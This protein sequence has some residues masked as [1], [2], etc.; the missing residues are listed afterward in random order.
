MCDMIAIIHSFQ[1][2]NF[3][4]QKNPTFIFY[5]FLYGIFQ[6]TSPHFQGGKKKKSPQKSPKLS[7]LHKESGSPGPSATSIVIC[8][9]AGTAFSRFATPDASREIDTSANV[10]INIYGANRE[11]RSCRIS[12]P[13]SIDS[14]QSIL[15]YNQLILP[16]DSSV[17]SPFFQYCKSLSVRIR[18][19]QDV[20]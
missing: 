13:F 4:I 20:M 3:L 2:Y 5:S 15:N 8:F 19:S 6:F 11:K 16:E 9:K 14:K 1:T 17:G 10:F 7:R 18:N 12:I